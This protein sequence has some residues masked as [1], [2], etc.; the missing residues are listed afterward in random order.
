MYSSSSPASLFAAVEFFPDLTSRD[1]WT[2]D[3]YEDKTPASPSMLWLLLIATP[4]TPDYSTLA[5]WTAATFFSSPL[6]ESF[7]ALIFLSSW[8][9][10]SAICSLTLAS[11]AAEETSAFGS[12]SPDAVD[13]MVKGFAALAVGA[14]CCCSIESL[15]SA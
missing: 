5:L 12:R 2:A 15:S 7:R 9:R 13:I 8:P 11:G 14:S 10:S 1:S 6:T 4:D 3:V